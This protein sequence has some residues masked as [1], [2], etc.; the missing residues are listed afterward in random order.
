MQRR[1][2]PIDRI[3]RETVKGSDGDEQGRQLGMIDDFEMQFLLADFCIHAEVERNHRRRSA[4]PAG[5]RGE[6][7]AGNSADGA[8]DIHDF[9]GSEVG[10]K[11]DEHAAA[12][13]RNLDV[14]EIQEWMP[15]KKNAVRL[16]CGYGTGGIYRRVALYQNHS[17]HIAGNNV[18]VVRTRRGGSTLRR[19]EAIALDLRCELLKGGGLKSGEDQRRLDGRQRGAYRNGK[20]R[21]CFLYRGSVK[22]KRELLSAASYRRTNDICDGSYARNGILRENTELQRKGARKLAVEINRAAAH[23]CDHAGALDFGPF[24]LNEDYRLLRAEEIGHYS[25]DFEIKPFHLV[26]SENRIRV[27]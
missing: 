24:E 16:Y 23:S 21:G 20:C 7:V 4:E 2:F 10:R 15:A 22:R 27:A 8:A 6:M 5:N 25:D 13:H 19:N 1:T 14:A 18:P 17:C 3:L 26:A 11:R 12:G 9:C